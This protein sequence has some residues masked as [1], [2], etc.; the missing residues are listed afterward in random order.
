MHEIVR[1]FDRRPAVGGTWLY[2]PQLPAAVPSIHKLLGGQDDEAVPIPSQFPVETAKSETVNGPQSHCADSGL[3]EH[4][5]TNIVALIMSFTKEP[6]PEPR[7]PPYDED[8][9]RFGTSCSSS[10]PFLRHVQ[11]RSKKANQRLRGLYQHTFDIEDQTLAFVGMWLEVW[12]AV[13]GIKLKKWAQLK[14][15]AEE[16][17]GQILAKL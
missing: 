9:V 7:P 12:A 2:T 11:D 1:V 6:F 16:E 8:H 10:L 17:I 5:N 14:E 15:K 13:P 3:H 4:L